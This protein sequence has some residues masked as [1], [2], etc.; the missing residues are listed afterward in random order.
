MTKVEGQL[1]ANNRLRA[2]AEKAREKALANP[3]GLQE[4][5]RD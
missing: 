5:L 4:G 3:C 2:A 1:K